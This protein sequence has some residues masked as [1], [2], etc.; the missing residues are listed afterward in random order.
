MAVE[1]QGRAAVLLCMSESQPQGWVVIERRCLSA[2]RLG[3]DLATCN[4]V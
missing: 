1:R 4:E 2:A 3:K